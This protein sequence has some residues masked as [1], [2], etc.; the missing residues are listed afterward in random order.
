MSI[1]CT[2]IDDIKEMLEG[3][4]EE[5]LREVM[6]FIAFLKERERKRKAFV[7][8]I[9]KIEAESDTVTFDS[10]KEAMEAIRN[11]SE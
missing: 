3:L 10:V 1:A 5:G 6:D 11:W 8:R 4:S 9:R 7:K 2:R